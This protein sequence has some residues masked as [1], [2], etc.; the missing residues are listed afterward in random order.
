MRSNWR[1]HRARE[2]ALSCFVSTV[3]NDR[4]HCPQC[5]SRLESESHSFMTAVRKGSDIQ[6]FIVGNDAAY[7]CS[8]CP[9]VV[10]DYGEF[11]RLAALSMR[12][13]KGV[14]FLVLGLIDLEAV[15]TEKRNVRF[16]DDTNPVPLVEFTNL[17]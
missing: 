16:D 6:P 11:E 14:E 13:S 17:K 7:F 5:P 4:S 1:L 3:V 2:T 15:P 9:V 10:L 12:T 8:T